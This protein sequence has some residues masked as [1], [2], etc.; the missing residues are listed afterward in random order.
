MKISKK[1]EAHNVARL[2]D[3]QIDRDRIVRINCTG[4]RMLH[5][6]QRPYIAGALWLYG[7]LTGE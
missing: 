4:L 5:L 2:L 6:V 3:L 1:V 7:P